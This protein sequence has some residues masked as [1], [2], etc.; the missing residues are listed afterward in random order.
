[1]TGGSLAVALFVGA[2]M[3][4]VYDPALWRAFRGLRPP[5]ERP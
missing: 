2:G 4:I 3:K 1:M 5:E